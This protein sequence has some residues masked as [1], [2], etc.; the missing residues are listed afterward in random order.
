MVFR[1]CFEPL[2]II[3]VAPVTTGMII[4]VLFHIRCISV[5]KRLYLISFLFPFAWHFCPLLLSRL[6]L[7]MI[8]VF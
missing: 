7:C 8:S 6:S 2:V 5:Y 1:F 3:S 4:H